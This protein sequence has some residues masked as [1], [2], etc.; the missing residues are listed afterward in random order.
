V[1]S[2]TLLAVA[3]ALLDRDVEGAP[4]VW[5]RACAFLGRQAVELAVAETWAARGLALSDA[6]MRAQLLCLGPILGD[7][8]LAGAASHA[9][10]ALTQ[11]CH[12]RSYELSPTREELGAWLTSVGELINRASSAPIAQPVGRRPGS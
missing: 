4:G 7:D 5:P 8:E 6:S 1:R 3:A 11:A 9:W 12:H 10:W 2:D